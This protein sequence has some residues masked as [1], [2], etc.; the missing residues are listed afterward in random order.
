MTRANYPNYLHLCFVYL[1]YRK[2]S[3]IF[4]DNTRAEKNNTKG[5]KMIG[6]KTEI[7]QRQCCDE[8]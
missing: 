7:E 6:M 8:L 5:I 3:F 4:L 1:F 2:P